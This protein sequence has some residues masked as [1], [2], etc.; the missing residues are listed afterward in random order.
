M[1]YAK[2]IEIYKAYIISYQTLFQYHTPKQ[3]GI[4]KNTQHDIKDMIKRS[5]RPEKNHALNKGFNKDIQK[6]EKYYTLQIDKVHKTHKT[7][8]KMTSIICRY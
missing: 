3:I 7:W 5:E 1:D 6:L 8:S 4:K 2:F